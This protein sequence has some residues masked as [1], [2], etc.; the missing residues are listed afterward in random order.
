MN[1]AMRVIVPSR[2]GSIVKFDCMSSD[3]IPPKIPIVL[4]HVDL[5]YI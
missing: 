1:G 2:F 3:E 4:L 5:R